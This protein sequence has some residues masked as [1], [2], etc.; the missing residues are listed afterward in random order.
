MDVLAL[1]PGLEQVVLA[2][3][4]KSPLV[5]NGDLGV[6]GDDLQRPRIQILPHHAGGPARGIASIGQLSRRWKPPR[7]RAGGDP[8]E[9]CVSFLHFSSFFLLSFIASNFFC[10]LFFHYLLLLS[11]F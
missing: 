3:L 8:D 7:N 11:R 10:L 1:P 9:F 5:T 4:N 2:V 6:A